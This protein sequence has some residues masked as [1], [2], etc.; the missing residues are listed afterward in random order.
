MRAC[1]ARAGCPWAAEGLQAAG[2]FVEDCPAP[3]L[4]GQAGLRRLT[5]PRRPPRAWPCTL[6]TRPYCLW[7]ISKDTRARP[8]APNVP[9][10]CLPRLPRHLQLPPES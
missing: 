8:G 3:G 10:Q 5:W 4:A 6:R 7:L 1:V 9:C 2:G